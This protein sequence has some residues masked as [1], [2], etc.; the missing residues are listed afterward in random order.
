[1]EQVKEAKGA[2]GGFKERL[3]RI[4]VLTMMQIK[5]NSKKKVR[6][7][8]RTAVTLVLSL[9]LFGLL[10]LVFF[11]FIR[12]MINILSLSFLTDYRFLIFYIMVLQVASII[13]CTKGLMQSLFLDKDNMILLS[14]PCRH[15]E[16]FLSKLLVFYISEFKKNFY[17]LGTFMVAF[18]F[19]Q[20]NTLLSEL[21]FSRPLYFIFLV[22]VLFILPLI[23]VLI[24]ALLS[25]PLAV[26][27]RL[28]KGN[29]VVEF[30][31]QIALILIL[32]VGT[33]LLV[34]NVLPPEIKVIKTY[35]YFLDD[36]KT[37]ISAVSKYGLYTKLIV[38]MM[39][40]SKPLINFLFILG[41]ISIGTLGVTFI[42][43]PF[44]FKIAS[45][46]MEEARMKAHKVSKDKK[47]HSIFYSFLKKDALIESRNL[48]GLI[49]DNLLLLLMPPIVV[50]MCGI[51]SRIA[52]DISRAPFLINIFMT[53]FILLLTFTNNEK[54]AV[55]IT[56][57]GS[58]F[59]LVKT[60]PNKTSTIAWSKLAML[61]II[62][63][64]MTILSYLLLYIGLKTTGSKYLLGS[65]GD[66]GNIKTPQLLLLMLITLISNAGLIFQAIE[67]DIRNPH[68]TEYAAT[69]SLK[70]NVNMRNINIFSATYSIL[71]TILFIVFNISSFTAHLLIPLILVTIYTVFRGALFR[72]YL[73][74]FFDEI[75][76]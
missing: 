46:S 54:A 45:H 26:L 75:E 41:I 12:I 51:Y 15:S 48:G 56:K 6:T 42:T 14:F 22:L 69:E 71:L 74:A 59:V 52:L 25:L 30:S 43:M 40:N 67:M 47:N 7:K 32:H 61:L 33:I 70:D 63:A 13:S 20:A 38:L 68:L 55:A 36:F 31:V 2:W 58:E 64:V 17:I 1:M 50:F 4:Q 10:T 21:P 76:L 8:G 16:V 3:E 24:G 39:F 57:E 28:I 49:Q 66:L 18:S 19:F 62:S 37:F 9:L 27:K 5:N 44:F 23:P 29:S 53:L 72:K 34:R 11:F 73:Y 60:A 65:T 35:A